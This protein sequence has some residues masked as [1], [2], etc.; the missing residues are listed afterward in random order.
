MHPSK[1]VLVSASQGTG[2]SQRTRASPGHMATG[3]YKESNLYACSSCLAN[4][5][6]FMHA[7]ECQP[8]DRGE[9]TKPCIYGAWPLAICKNPASACQPVTANQE[10]FQC[11][12]TA[13]AIGG[14]SSSPSTPSNS[15]ST[16]L[17]AAAS[18][19]TPP[20]SSSPPSSP[21]SSPSSSSSP[22]PASSPPPSSTPQGQTPRL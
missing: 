11:K 4:V 6:N 9:P 15:S 21:S 7:G 20:A 5:A 10:I 14:G 12:P 1:L 2:A 19:S 13:L 16:A 18:S 3:N 8:R 17:N 22:T